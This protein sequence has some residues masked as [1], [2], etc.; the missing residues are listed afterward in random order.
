MYPYCILDYEDR[1]FPKWKFL[2]GT[3]YRWCVP[4]TK[5]PCP[6]HGGR[7]LTFCRD[8]LGRDCKGRRLDFF[9]AVYVSVRWAK[10]GFPACGGGLRVP[11]DTQTSESRCCIHPAFF[12]RPRVG[13][14]RSGNQG[15]YS[16]R[17]AIVQWT[18]RPRTELPRTFVWGHIAM[19][20]LDERNDVLQFADLLVGEG[21]G[22]VKERGRNA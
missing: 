4:W 10:L 12:M 5:R 21:A 3:S 22:G 11:G 15:T 19:S 9:D 18:Q 7:G 20:P 8:R 6:I 1:C 14:H 17:D 13:T 2:N 16:E